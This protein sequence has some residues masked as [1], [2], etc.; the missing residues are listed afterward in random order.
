MCIDHHR[1]KGN[2]SNHLK[3][4]A[5]HVFPFFAP[6]KVDDH[7]FAIQPPQCSEMSGQ[8]TQIIRLLILHR[9]TIHSFGI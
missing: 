9:I 8:Q 3:C 7:L 6:E 2:G 5:E 1:G 4:F